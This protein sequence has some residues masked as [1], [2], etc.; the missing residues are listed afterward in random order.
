VS[1]PFWNES[2]LPTPE[3]VDELIRQRQAKPVEHR[4]AEER[5][6]A[7]EEGRPTWSTPGGPGQWR[8]R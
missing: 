1:R 3:M 7:A 6:R 8:H 2:S 5:D 4:L